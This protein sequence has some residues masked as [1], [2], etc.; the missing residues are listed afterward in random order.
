MS[1]LGGKLTFMIKKLVIG[2]GNIG[3]QLIF[4]KYLFGG[5]I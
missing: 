4:P 2:Q 3:A 1:G 5:Y